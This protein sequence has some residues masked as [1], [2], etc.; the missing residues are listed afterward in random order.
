[1][2]YPAIIRGQNVADATP[3]GEAE[4][5]VLLESNGGATTPNLCDSGTYNGLYSQSKV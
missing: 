3:K 5:I 4:T 2:R 1:M